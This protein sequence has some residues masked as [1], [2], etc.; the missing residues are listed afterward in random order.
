MLKQIKTKFNKYKHLFFL[1]V[2]VGLIVHLPLFTKDILSADILLNN[3]YYSGYSWEVS[4]GRFGLFIVGLLK[5]YIVIPHI[6]LF[7]SLLL[8]GIVSIELIDL[9]QIKNKLLQI[10]TCFILVVCPNVSTTLL[11]NYCSLPYTIAFASSITAIYLLLKANNKYLKYILPAILI[12]IA[13]SMYQAYL[14]VP[15]SLLVLYYIKDLLNN[16]FDFKETLKQILVVVISVIM[17]FILMKLSQL[18]LHIDMSN[19]TNAS[20]FGLKNILSI[21]LH[22]L[23]T[24][25]VFFEY[26]FTDTILTNTTLYNHLINALLLIVLLIN[27][28]SLTVKN[29]LSL[30][31]KLILLFFVLTL[32]IYFN[33]ILLIMPDATMQLLMSSSYI[34]L[35]PLIFSLSDNTK[36]YKII[37]ILLTILLIRN[38]TIQDNATYK[39]LEITNNKTYTI[40]LDLTSKINELG[41]DKKIM[42][43]GNLQ[44]NDYYNYNTNLEIDNINNLTYG[45]ISE[46]SLFW[47][48]YTN[49]KNGWTRYFYQYLG[50]NIN[51]V[52]EETYNKILSSYEFKELESY[53]DKDSIKLID[54]VIVIKI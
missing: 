11:F 33:C 34:L 50:T 26:F 47:D 1:T 12:I 18:V 4:L 16:K 39:V 44:N 37:F 49:T 13:L 40:A 3:T 41:Y 35:I 48:E 15:I 54:N 23:T 43:T 38:Y 29:K 32:P 9:F 27:I 22:I 51:F 45:Y 14:A 5:S 20:S 31:N 7:L 2:I 19:Y 10:L 30:T 46:Y 36:V 24:Y 21:P 8:V 53:P 17:Y 28:I 42:I 6:E 52:D 25:Q